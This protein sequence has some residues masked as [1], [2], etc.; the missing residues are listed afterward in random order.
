[1]VANSHGWASLARGKEGRRKKKEREREREEGRK[2]GTRTR[3]A[4]DDLHSNCIQCNSRG[5]SP[6][7]LC[8]CVYVAGRRNT[9]AIMI[10]AYAPYGQERDRPIPVSFR[11]PYITGE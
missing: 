11:A 9:I 3:V 1:M 10:A 7:T 2:E 8:V 6:Q 4:I 5:V